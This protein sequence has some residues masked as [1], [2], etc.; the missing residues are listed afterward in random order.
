LV[1]FSSIGNRESGLGRPESAMGES[2]RASHIAESRDLLLTA[3][4]LASDNGGF[5]LLAWHFK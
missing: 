3:S 1:A 5:P 4:A 2:G